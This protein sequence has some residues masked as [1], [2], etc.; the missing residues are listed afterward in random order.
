M[1]NRMLM[2]KFESHPVL[3]KTAKGGRKRARK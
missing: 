3:R 2:R 1:L